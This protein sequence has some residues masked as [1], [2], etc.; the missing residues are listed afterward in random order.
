[1]TSGVVGLPAGGFSLEGLTAV[2]TGASRNIGA[3]LTAAFAEAGADVVMVARDEPRL[4]AMAAIIAGRSPQRRIITRTADLGVRDSVDRLIESIAA[5]V[6]VVDILV[7]NAAAL[8]T[9]TD[10]PILATSDEAWDQLYET[11]LLSPFRLIRGLV[12]PMLDAGR[13]GSVINVL[14][15]AGFLPVKDQCAYG[16]MKAALWMMTRYLAQDLAPNVRV[17]A[18]VPGIVSHTGAPRS[19]A[20]AE[21]VQTAVPFGRVGRPEEIT[22]AAV[23]LS[24]PAASYTSG[25]VIFCN[26]AR[27]W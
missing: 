5:D 11:N 4:A 7:N 3:S 12:A 24:S 16:S 15:G 18:L 20:Q 2:I 14:S 27:A 13:T 1:V 8:A 10:V 22:G 23:Y 21:V 9:T 25:E 19:P 6:G 17:N 26:G